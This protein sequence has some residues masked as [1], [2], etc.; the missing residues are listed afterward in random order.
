VP[1]KIAAPYGP[2]T[3]ENCGVSDGNVASDPDDDALEAQ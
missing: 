1:L 3:F 2:G